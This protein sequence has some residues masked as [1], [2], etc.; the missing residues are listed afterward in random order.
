MSS[1]SE[2]STSRDLLCS[3]VG[4]MLPGFAVCFRS[5]LGAPMRMIWQD[6]PRV[7][8]LLCL[9]QHFR[10]VCHVISRLRARVTTSRN[11]ESRRRMHIAEVGCSAFERGFAAS[12]FPSGADWIPFSAI[13]AIGGLASLQSSCQKLGANNSYPKSLARI[14]IIMTPGSQATEI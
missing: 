6:A 1:L 10:V 12:C 5:I 8:N 11:P 7:G 2:V 3:G 13:L 14:Q 9:S 4:S